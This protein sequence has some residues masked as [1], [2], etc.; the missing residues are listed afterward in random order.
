MDGIWG[1][2]RLLWRHRIVQVAVGYVAVAWILFQGVAAIKQTW[3]LPNWVDQ[4]AMVILVVGLAPT[5]IAAW[6]LRSI[7]PPAAPAE[8]SCA[9]LLAAPGAP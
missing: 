6:T 4:A 5:L 3:N 8:V 7:A 1:Y 9:A 2:L